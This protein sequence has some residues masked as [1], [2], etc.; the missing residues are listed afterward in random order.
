MYD[1][2]LRE[3]AALLEGAYIVDHEKMDN[4]V[5][6][7]TYDNGVAVYVNYS[8]SK[9]TVDGYEV[10]AMSYKVGEAK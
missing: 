1:T 8:Q 7:V 10:E 2:K 5:T 9:A 6:K 4:G 3:V